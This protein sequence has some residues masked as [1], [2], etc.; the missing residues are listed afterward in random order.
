MTNEERFK[1]NLEDLLGA[2]EFPFDEANWKDARDLIDASKAKRR[3]VMPF[4]ILGL[5]VLLGTGVYLLSNISAADQSLADTKT[6][7][8]PQQKNSVTEI[9]ELSTKQRARAEVSHPAS[10]TPEAKT[11]LAPVKNQILSSEIKPAEKLKDQTVKSQINPEIKGSEDQAI[12]ATIRPTKKKA[13]PTLLNA[14]GTKKKT[15]APAEAELPMA[16]GTAKTTPLAD[17]KTSSLP[18]QKP[19]IASGEKTAATDITPDETSD[20]K[21]PSDDTF[22][23]DAVKS[24]DPGLSQDKKEQVAETS[25][26]PE[27]TASSSPAKDEEQSTFAPNSSN[28]PDTTKT[29][30]ASSISAVPGD[31]ADGEIGK[32]KERLVLFSTEAGAN[33]MLGWKNPDGRDANGFDPVF[34]I[35]YFTNFKSKMAL[36]VGLQYTSV[37][38][39]SYSNYTSRVI[40]LALGEESQVSV[41]TPTKLHYLIMPLRFEYSV[42]PKNALGIGCNIAYLVTTESTVE[43][44]SEKMATKYDVSTS[45]EKGYTKGFKPYDTQISVFYK[46]ALH[47]NFAVNMEFYYGLT[48]IKDNTFFNSKVIERNTGLKLTLVYNFLK[49]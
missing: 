16:T 47:P 17:E 18:E 2:K 23:S 12:A 10:K 42:N 40:R 9:P 11:N 34:G 27:P 37:S 41:Y 20:S 45:K 3:R 36:T 29:A 25:S 39:L 43:T 32:T 4:F 30:Q 44:Y 24:E 38:K 7:L 13:N 1:K 49:K 19:A 15:S 48:D 5:V 14:R 22:A 33:Y 8:I 21:K 28:I 35:N 31:N 26:S 6:H 46:R